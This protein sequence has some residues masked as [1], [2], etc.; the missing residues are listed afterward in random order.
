MKNADHAMY[1]AKNSGRNRYQYY[2][3]AM[4]EEA[5]ERMFMMNDLRAA[6]AEHPFVLHYQPIIELKTGRIQKAEALIRW[7]HP[8]RGLINPAE[9]IPISEQS[10]MIDEITD[11]VFRTAAAQTAIWRATTHPDFQVTINL[12]PVVFLNEQNM[13]ASWLAQLAEIGLSGQGIAVEI[14]EGILLDGRSSITDRMLALRDA[15][16]QVALDDFGTGFCSLSYLKK[17]DID[18]IKIDRSFIQNLTPGSNDMALVEAIIVMAHKLGLEVV[19]EGVETVDQHA[20][21]IQAG[22]DYAQGV[23]FSKPLPPEE[24][25]AFLNAMPGLQR[26]SLVSG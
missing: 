20:L 18:Y 24:L 25:E 5:R 26:L 22:C 6:L 2:V 23:L 8:E 17:F 19:A 4:Q 7:Q 16:I 10:G 1:A 3:P 14:T 11:W 15:G 13:L 9:F 12:S 21:L